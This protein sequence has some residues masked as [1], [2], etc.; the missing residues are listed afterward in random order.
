MVEITRRDMLGGLSA[1][2]LAASGV[3]PA[4][5]QAWPSR[6][7]TLVHGLPPGGS[8]D[9]IARIV[10]EGLSSRLGQPVVIE[11]KPG[12]GGT[13]AA[14]QVARAAPD[15]YTLLA[16]PSG[17]AVSAAMYK[18][19]PYAP[20]D[21]FTFIGMTTEY[22]LVVITYA[23]SPI[24]NLKD[25]IA[26]AQGDKPLLYGCPNGT[27]QHL[28]TELLAYKTK[29]KVQQV[30]YRGSPQAVLD[31][32]GKRIDFMI[33]PPTAHMQ[34][35]Q[36]GGLRALAVT[37]ANRFFALPDVPTIAEIAVPGFDVTSWQGVI[38][39]AN[40]PE[41]IVTRLNAELRAIVTDPKTV[42]K[43]KILGNDANPSTP[44]EFKAKVASD[45][46]KWVDVVATAKIQQI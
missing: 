28:T 41:P 25:L 31:L 29:M 35:I 33:D 40:L 44:Q 1:T 42:E 18:T 6:P 39:P 5:A 14:A 19:L 10:G 2:G 16:I 45:L 17:H 11:A 8:V 12:A 13:S 9:A 30:P 21:D 22:P 46:A 37:G 34:A 3:L 32:M 38:G 26:T 43:L 24:K 7:I 4:A 15:G 23:E 27:G 20:V 36:S